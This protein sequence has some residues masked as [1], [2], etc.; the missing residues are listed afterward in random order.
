MALMGMAK[1][2]PALG[3]LMDRVLDWPLCHPGGSAEDCKAYLLQNFR[4]LGDM[5]CQ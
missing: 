3:Q 4:G 5:Q 1:G 2:G